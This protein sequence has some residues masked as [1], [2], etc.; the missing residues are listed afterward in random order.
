[1]KRETKQFILGI[2]L[3]LFALFEYKVHYFNFEAIL[4]IIIG[5]TGIGFIYESLD[6]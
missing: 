3:M 5:L 2:L 6:N 1:M 4:V